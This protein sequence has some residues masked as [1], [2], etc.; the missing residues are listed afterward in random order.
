MFEQRYDAILTPAASR[1]RPERARVDRRPRL[2][3]PVD[4][5]WGAGAQRSAGKARE[6]PA[7]GRPARRRPSPRRAA[8]S[9]GAR[10]VAHP[11]ERPL[12]RIIPES[13]PRRRHGLSPALAPACQPSQATI[14]SDQ[15]RVTTA[16][17]RETRRRDKGEGAARQP[18]E[19]EPTTG[20]TGAPQPTTLHGP[21]E[22]PSTPTN[23][24]TIPPARLVPARQ[25]ANRPCSRRSSTS[26]KYAPTRSDMARKRARSIVSTAKPHSGN[27]YGPSAVNQKSATR[28]RKSSFCPSG[29]REPDNPAAA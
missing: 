29:A 27:P 8:A 28:D 15:R 10:L 7:A 25:P 11:L 22:R 4:A 20:S 23:A 19:D 1:H 14:E 13:L 16:A 18:G 12:A 6:R 3:R 21:V 9:N 17:T 26:A 2:L 24:P 5:V